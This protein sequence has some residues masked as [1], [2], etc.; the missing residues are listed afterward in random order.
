[1]KSKKT[2]NPS[3]KKTSKAIPAAEK[4]LPPFIQMARKKK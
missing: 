2:S 1:M 4:K 3:S